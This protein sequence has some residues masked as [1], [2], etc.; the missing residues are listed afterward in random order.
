MLD[1]DEMT[2]EEIEAMVQEWLELAEQEEHR[3]SPDAK[4]E[5]TASG[6]ELA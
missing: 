1:G 5:L 2:Y 3:E 6:E 4:E